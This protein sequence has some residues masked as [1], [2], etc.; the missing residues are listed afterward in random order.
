[1]NKITETQNIFR[2]QVKNWLH[3]LLVLM[4]LIATY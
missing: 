2:Q 4:C 3:W 1:M